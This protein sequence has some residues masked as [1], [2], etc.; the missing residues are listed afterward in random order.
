MS[1]YTEVARHP[2]TGLYEVAKFHDDY[3]GPR[4]YGVEFPSDGKVYPKDLVDKKHVYTFW[5]E[6]VKQAFEMLNGWEDLSDFLNYIEDE[7][8]ARW[9][10][11]PIGGEG[12][13]DWLNTMIGKDWRQTDENS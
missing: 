10:R 13:T 5:V 2:Q 6:D 9:Q 7:Y 4:L 8:K 3:F 1:T 12:A 11:D